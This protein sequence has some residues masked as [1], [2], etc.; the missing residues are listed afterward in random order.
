MNLAAAQLDDPSLAAH[1]ADLL[2]IHDV[3][4]RHLALEVTETTT[5]RD[6]VRS[7]QAL[8]ELAERGHHISL[9]DFGTGYSSLERLRTLPL[10][11]LK[12]DRSPSHVGP[13][14]RWVK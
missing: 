8:G 3:P 10:D 5:M 12:I 7:S 11:Q 6:P 2:Q 9:D 14:S 13:F 4:A 1:I